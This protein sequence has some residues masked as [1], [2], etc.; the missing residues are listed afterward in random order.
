MITSPSKFL[1]IALAGATA[2][3]LAACSTGE[4]GTAETTTAVADAAAGAEDAGSSAEE[5]TWPRTITHELGETVIEEKPERIANT[6]IS[7]TGTLLAMDAPVSA[8]AAAG[9]SGMTDEQGFFTQWSDVADERGVEVLYDGLEFDMES[10]IAADPDLVILSV[11]G[12]DSVADHYEEISAQFPTIAVD[13]SKQTWQELATELGA[14]LGLEEE[15]ENAITEFDDYATAAAE[16]IQAPEGGVSIVSYNGPG[17]EQGIGK[18]TGPHAELLETLGLDVVEADPA[19]D[20][21]GQKRSDFS[22]V[23]F[24]NLSRAATGE[25]VFLLR[26]TADTVE[27]FKGEAVLANLPAVQNDAVHPLGENSFRVDPF[28]GREIVDAVETALS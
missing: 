28:S 26:G 12:N 27:K 2:L 21:R 8:S 1:S 22:F 17:G 20:T 18:T 9:V 23:S 6:A 4:G 16:R 15:A 11:S 13:Y 25:A 19:L 5:G 14:A 7:V 3:T 24:E 10:L